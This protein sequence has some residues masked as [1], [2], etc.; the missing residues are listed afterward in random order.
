[1][2]HVHAYVTS[3]IELMPVIKTAFAQNA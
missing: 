1:L 3:F 2:P